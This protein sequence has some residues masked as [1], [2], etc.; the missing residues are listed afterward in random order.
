MN[1]PVVWTF[2]AETG[3]AEIIGYLEDEWSEKEVKNFV[4]R[5]RKVIKHISCFPQMFEASPTNPRVRKALIAKQQSLFY[6][7]EEDCIVLLSFWDNR[8]KP[9]DND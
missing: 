9:E 3:F 8:R 1:L 2:E 4:H 5:V 7:I 6:Q